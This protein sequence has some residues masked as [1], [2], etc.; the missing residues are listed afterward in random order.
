MQAE[1]G[2][3]ELEKTLKGVNSLYIVTP[4]RQNPAELPLATAV[5]AKKA[6]VKHLALITST[7]SKEFIELESAIK[8]LGVPYTIFRLAF[9]VDNFFWSRETIKGAGAIFAPVDSTKRFGVAVMED[10]AKATA[11]VLVDPSNHANKIYNIISDRVTHGEI[12]TALEE[13]LGKKVTYTRVTYDDTNKALL[14]HGFPEWRVD[15][16]ITV[17]KMFDSG[18]AAPP[19]GDYEKITGEKPTD[20]KSWVAQVKGAF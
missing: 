5:S 20:F 16:V 7:T 18:Y 12:A 4:S 3:A 11:A 9:F 1:M 2:T 10:I 17:Y 19:M 8:T 15:R 6:G 13:A 14:D